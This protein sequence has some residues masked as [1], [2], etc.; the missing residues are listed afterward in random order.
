MDGWMDEQQFLLILAKEQALYGYRNKRSFSFN[1]I[2]SHDKREE[3]HVRVVTY[4]AY[5]HFSKCL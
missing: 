3:Q 5:Y 1:I 2:L 4:I